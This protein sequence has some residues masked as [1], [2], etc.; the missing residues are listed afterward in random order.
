MTIREL[1][2]ADR[3][4]GLRLA[5]LSPRHRY[6]KILHQPGAYFNEVFNFMMR[7][8]YMQPHQHP[9]SEKI[10]E[11][12]IVEGRV[13]ILFF[14]NDGKVTISAHL[15]ADQTRVVRVPAFAWHTYVISSDYAI[16]YETMDGVY[17][18][19]TW[20]ALAPW[21]PIETATEAVSFLDGLRRV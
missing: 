18:P 13:K 7:D 3:V 17:E 20:K 4:D 16:T 21:A 11:I 14:D 8:S 10:E 15:A 6:A 19:A 5:K 9:G 2:E 1:P 12:H